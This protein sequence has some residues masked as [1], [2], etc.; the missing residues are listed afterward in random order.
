MHLDAAL[1][2]TIETRYDEMVA[3]LFPSKIATASLGVMG[4]IGAIPSITGILEW[5]RIR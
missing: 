5:L 3:V 1:P 2:V 4:V